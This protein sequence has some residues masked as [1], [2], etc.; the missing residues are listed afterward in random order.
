MGNQHG[1]VVLHR[2]T[3]HPRVRAHGHHL[4][5]GPG[6]G[7]WAHFL[8]TLCK[9]LI[10]VDLSPKCIEACKKRFHS[11]THIL[12][13]ANDGT[14]LDMIPDRSVNFVFSFDSLAYG[15]ANVIERYL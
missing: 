6:H 7:R 12:Y 1:R 5:I 3:A 2:A 13:H 10:L 11:D 8:R 9:K 14:S 15:E 4:G